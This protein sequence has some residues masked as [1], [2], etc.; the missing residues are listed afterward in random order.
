MPVASLSNSTA[1]ATRDTNCHSPSSRGHVQSGDASSVACGSMAPH[2]T[3]NSDKDGC[4]WGAV[5]LVDEDGVSIASEMVAEEVDD[6][7]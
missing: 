4:A 5:A 1:L 3:G 2:L 6:V 7:T